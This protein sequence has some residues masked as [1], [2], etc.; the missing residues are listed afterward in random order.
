[1]RETCTMTVDVD[2]IRTLTHDL[3]VALGE[4]PDRH[5]CRTAPELLH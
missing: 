5:E 4:D 2:R 1:M 3:L